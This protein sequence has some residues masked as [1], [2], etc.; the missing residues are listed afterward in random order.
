MPNLCAGLVDDAELR[1]PFSLSG[2][3]MASWV[4]RSGVKPPILRQDV[5]P[6]AAF[7]QRPRLMRQKL[8]L[9]RSPIYRKAVQD[10]CPISHRSALYERVGQPSRCVTR[11][12]SAEMP[13]TPRHC[14]LTAPRHYGASLGSDAGLTHHVLR[15]GRSRHTQAGP[16]PSGRYS[17][18]ALPIERSLGQYLT[19]T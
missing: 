9:K 1:V 7:P 13:R 16:M 2:D 6:G 12:K 14:W 19:K 11:R 5:L 17:A 8:E 18:R 3:A 4:R 15:H 10:P